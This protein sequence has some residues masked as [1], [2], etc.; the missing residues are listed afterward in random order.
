MYIIKLIIIM[1]I[2]RH[3]ISD[4]LVSIGTVFVVL[5]MFTIRQQPAN[6][7]NTI[8]MWTK[9][10]KSNG[11]IIILLNIIIYNQFPKVRTYVPIHILLSDLKQTK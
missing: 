9:S 5:I 2:T 6:Y 7:V 1:K 4:M 11:H 3:I 8:K 10:S